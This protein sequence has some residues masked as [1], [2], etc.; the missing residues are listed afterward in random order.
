VRKAEQLVYTTRNARIQQE[1]N[2]ISILLGKNQG[3]ISKSRNS[4]THLALQQALSLRSLN[5]ARERRRRI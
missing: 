2:L 4:Q 3:P 1:E 5:A